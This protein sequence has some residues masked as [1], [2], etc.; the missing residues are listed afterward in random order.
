MDII[1]LS[2]LSN[3]H[4]LAGVPL[5][6]AYT[7][8]MTHANAGAQLSYFQSKT[9]YTMVEAVPLR[10]GAV[11]VPYNY[12]NLVDCNYLIYQNQNFSNKWFYAFIIGRE[13]I[14]ANVTELTLQIDV[15]ETFQFDI[16]FGTSMIERMHVT[17]D[18]A[19]HYL[20]PEPLDSSMKV[21][22]V[23]DRTYY[24]DED[25]T[26]A[27]WYI[28]QDGGTVAN[29][30][31]VPNMCQ[32]EIVPLV[33]MENFYN[34]TIKPLIEVGLQDNV[35][36]A[37]MKPAFL[38]WDG[39]SYRRSINKAQVF[40]KLNDYVPVNQKLLT[41]PFHCI[42]VAS[43][44]GV[45]AT[46]LYEYMH[47]ATMTFVVRGMI[48]IDLT[49]YGYFVGYQTQLEDSPNMENVSIVSGFPQPLFCGLQ[50]LGYAQQISA[51]AMNA[52]AGI[53]DKVGAAFQAIKQG[54][55]EDMSS[56]YGDRVGRLTDRVMQSVGDVTESR[57]RDVERAAQGSYE[58]IGSL[59]QSTSSFAA[60]K[61]N[62]Y[63][64][65][66]SVPQKTA[67]VY[68]QYLT[69]WG[70]SVNIYA[71]PALNTRSRFN[72]LKTRGV[73]IKGNIPTESRIALA[74]MFD[75]GVTI[76]HQDKGVEPGGWDGTAAGNPVG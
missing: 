19:G 47:E 59:P 6:P 35:I 63:F 68:D 58:R 22:N 75:R 73:V 27:V 76:W 2:P 8:V 37:V 65:T 70:Y 60:W 9:K 55:T 12:D 10:N 29:S 11:R 31:I 61:G 71:T 7:D 66:E 51:Q 49:L 36:G 62:F 34:T 4:I 15:W 57:I 20:E 1:P 17:D 64:L 43:A 23:V 67:M 69:R 3:V 33:S 30:P 50:S 28:P 56:V 24:G 14:N 21:T 26:V 72:F 18:V 48:S 42:R 45:Q 5:T 53:K 44:N 54:L 39:A 40:G 52:V 46:Y 32:E 25:Y 13:Y 16:F 38:T 74:A 41:Y